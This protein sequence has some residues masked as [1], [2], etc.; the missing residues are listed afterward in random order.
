[1]QPMMRKWEK[2]LDKVS[3]TIVRTIST[4]L[5]EILP[6]GWIYPFKVILIVSLIVLL[7]CLFDQKIWCPLG[8][9]FLP[10]DLCHQCPLKIA[11]PPTHLLAEKSLLLAEQLS[12][13][14]LNTAAQLVLTRTAFLQIHFNCSFSS[15]KTVRQELVEQFDELKELIAGG[16]EKSSILAASFRAMVNQMHN[17]IKLAL[18][19]LQEISY[20]HGELVTN[21]D[22]TEKE[23]EKK[24]IFLHSFTRLERNDDEEILSRIN[25]INC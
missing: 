7:A 20:R 1:M 2:V 5:W 8:C 9:L 24:E 12:D 10:E 15:R 18:H 17:A 6:L 19:G 22:T 4:L 16:V 14:D 3:L 11:L 13:V 23:T 21:N 25:E